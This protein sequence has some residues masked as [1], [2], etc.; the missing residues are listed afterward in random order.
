MSPETTSGYRLRILHL[1]DLHER[2]TREDKSWRRERVLGDAWEDNLSILLQDGPVDLVCFTGDVADW[3]KAQEYE[4]AT[5]FLE[6]LL[7]RLSLGKDRLF[8]ISGNHD[9]AR[10]IAQDAWHRLRERG[11]EGI[12]T[13]ALSRWMAGHAGPPPGI[14]PAWQEQI[15]AR[16]AA[17]R[18]W[19]RA[20]LGRPDLDPKHS[21]HGFLGYRATVHLHGWDFGVHIL[22]LDTAWL[23]GDDADAG[24]LRLTEDQLMRLATD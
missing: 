4:A 17:Y 15:L 21:P 8:V 5:G 14:E 2:G 11:Q 23:A 16:Q 20:I 19:V 10:P 3:G 22:G 7:A 13:Q 18:D 12:D 6:A 1:S 9:I 24:R